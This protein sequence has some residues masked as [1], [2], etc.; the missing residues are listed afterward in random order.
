MPKFYITDGRNEFLIDS[1][2]YLHACKKAIKNWEKSNRKIGR[3]VCFNNTGFD[4]NNNNDCIETKIIKG[5]T[6]SE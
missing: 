5:L 6:I 4:L 1:K 2:T 3:F